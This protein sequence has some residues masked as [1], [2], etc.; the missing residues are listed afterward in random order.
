MLGA[1][2]VLPPRPSQWFPLERLRDTARGANR[3]R[4][5]SRWRSP[6]SSDVKGG[7]SPFP[8]MHRDFSGQPEMSLPLWPGRCLAPPGLTWGPGSKVAAGGILHK[9]PEAWTASKGP[10]EDPHAPVS[11]SC[12]HPGRVVPLPCTKCPGTGRTMVFLVTMWS[13]PPA[14]SKPAALPKL[15]PV[16]C[17]TVLPPDPALPV[18]VY[19]GVE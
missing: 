3:G 12:W 14:P 13:H 7:T 1:C 4:A 19:A 8:E 10:T 9:S 17:C 16:G 18:P 15:A 2:P 5:F 6:Q 11:C